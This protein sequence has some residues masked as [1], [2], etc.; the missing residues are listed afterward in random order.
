MNLEQLAQ[1]HPYYC[2]DNNF[3]SND[4][5]QFYDTWEDFYRA[6]KEMDVDL[7]L[8]FRFDVKKDEDTGE[9]SAYIFIMQQR[10][11]IFR[12]NTISSVKEENVPEM[13]EYLQKHYNQLQELWTPFSTKTK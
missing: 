13:V 6:E 9:Y 11:G 8:C 5:S 10:K 7:N 4:P 2:S 12:P 3:Y 1:D